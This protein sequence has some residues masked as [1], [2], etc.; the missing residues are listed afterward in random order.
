M[1]LRIFG[2]IVVADLLCF[3]VELISHSLFE[4]YYRFS[5][6]LVLLL[7]FIFFRCLVYRSFLSGS[8]FNLSPSLFKSSSSLGFRL[9]LF[10]WWVHF[11]TLILLFILSN[12]RLSL[13]FISSRLLSLLSLSL[14]REGLTSSFQSLWKRVKTLLSTVDR[15]G[16]GALNLIHFGF[17]LTEG[18]MQLLFDWLRS[19]LLTW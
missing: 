11:N 2:F 5:D 7:C 3:S 12:L 16:A 10:G 14:G 9:S 18:E 8:L 13:S 4:A 17:H 19:S 6:G 15:V 1:L